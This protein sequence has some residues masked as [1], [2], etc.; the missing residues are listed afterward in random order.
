MAFSELPDLIRIDYN[1]PGKSGLSL[2]KDLD[3]YPQMENVPIIMIT[4]IGL[5]D[6]V[7]TAVEYGV[8][9]L[10]VKPCDINLMVDRVMKLVPPP[11]QKEESE[12]PAQADTDRFRRGG[13]R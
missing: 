11:P 8:T 5:A 10:I 7:S 2:L 6:I 4:G 13:I 3:E 9:D 1:L 12:A